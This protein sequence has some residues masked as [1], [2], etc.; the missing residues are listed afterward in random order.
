MTR[1]EALY[2]GQMGGMSVQ[3]TQSLITALEALGLLKFDEVRHDAS[4]DVR[5]LCSCEGGNENYNIRVEQWPEGLVLWVSGEIVWK[6]WVDEIK[7]TKTMIDVMMEAL[8]KAGY[9]IYKGGYGREL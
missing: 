8:K 6:D 5:K 4:R 9:R 7:P 2:K 3:V 1:E